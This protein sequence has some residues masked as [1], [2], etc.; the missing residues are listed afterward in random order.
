MWA[1]YEDPHPQNGVSL[2]DARS[3]D[4]IFGTRTETTDNQIHRALVSDIDPRYPGMECWA[5]GFFYTCTGEPIAGPVPPLKGLVWWDAD[6]LREIEE[7]GRIFKWKG[8][9]LTSGIEGHVMLWADLV[10]DWREEVVTCTRSN[11]IRIY[12]TVIP[13]EDR[14]VC[15]MQDP[16]YRMDVALKAMGYDQVP[17]TGYYLGE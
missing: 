3:G 17:M 6:R 7:N 4:L 1:S 10:G 8:Q 16:L 12:T 14:R 15:L 9:T 2:W 11:E 13:A 5:T